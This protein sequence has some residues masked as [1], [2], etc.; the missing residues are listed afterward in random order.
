MNDAL[1]TR[2][3]WERSA[4]PAP[5]T[6]ALAEDV[7]ADVVVIGAAD[8]GLSSALHLADRGAS[9]VVLE[10]HDI[11]SGGSGRNVGLV[12]AGMWVMPEDL[13]CALGDLHVSRLL[14]LLG[15]A[16]NVVFNLVEKYAINCEAERSGTLHCGVGAG[17]LSEL[18]ERERQWRMIVC[19]VPGCE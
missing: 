1:Q 5:K 12:N 6:F 13:R 4:P 16:P 7:A 14:H 15:D 10:G 3:L 17:G 19:A 18:K 8:T 2:G 9:V 11:G